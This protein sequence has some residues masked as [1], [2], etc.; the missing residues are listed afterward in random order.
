MN[1]AELPGGSV[2][3]VEPANSD[4]KQTPTEEAPGNQSGHGE[5]DVGYYGPAS[6]ESTKTES[7]DMS[8]EPKE[9]DGND[10]DDDLD[11]F[12]DSLR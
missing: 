9:N 8:A 12:F 6:A 3:H 1:G 11:D 7:R 4:Y 2:L 5:H 10:P